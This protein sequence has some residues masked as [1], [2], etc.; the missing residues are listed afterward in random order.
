MEELFKS[1]SESVSEECFEDIL[2]M[3]EEL[4]N[5]RNDRELLNRAKRKEL[6]W[7]EAKKDPFNYSV[8]KDKLPYQAQTARNNAYHKVLTRALRREGLGGR[9]LEKELGNRRKKN[10]LGSDI[11]M[12]KMAHDN[13]VKVLGQQVKEHPENIEKVARQ[14]M[15]TPKKDGDYKPETLTKKVNGKQALKPDKYGIEGVHTGKYSNS[16]PVHV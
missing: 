2:N 4:L 13:R 15:E 1:L 10:L 7:K 11:D 14:A 16:F 5:E 9:K 3:V 12:S 8:T 6:E